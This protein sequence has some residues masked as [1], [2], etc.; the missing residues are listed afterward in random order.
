MIG[1]AEIVDSA[2]I[3]FGDWLASS[4]AGCFVKY[5]GTED[6]TRGHF[7]LQLPAYVSPV[8]IIFAGVEPIPATSIGR[9]WTKTF[10]QPYREKYL[11]MSGAQTTLAVTTW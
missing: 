6:K 7:S 4:L 10:L 9:P 8:M 5:F 3:Y 2:S 1:L 11:N